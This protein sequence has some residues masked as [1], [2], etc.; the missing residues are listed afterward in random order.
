MSSYIS[1]GQYVMHIVLHNRLDMGYEHKI[2]NGDPKGK[3]LRVRSGGR[4]ENNTITGL[5]CPAFHIHCVI[6]P[7]RV[8]QVCVCAPCHSSSIERWKPKQLQ[9]FMHVPML[10]VALRSKWRQT[11]RLSVT[12]SV[13][14]D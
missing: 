13:M 1:F 3:R 2:L 9:I 12:S 4:M 14:T 7:V 10:N 11:V 5:G 8:Y 6:T